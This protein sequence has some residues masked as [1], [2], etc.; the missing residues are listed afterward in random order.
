[1]AA[2]LQRIHMACRSYKSNMEFC[3]AKD[4]SIHRAP[5]CV[6]VP[7]GYHHRLDNGSNLG[8]QRNLLYLFFIMVLK[9]PEFNKL[10]WLFLI[11]KQTI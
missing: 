3:F 7:E 9:V 4:G 8:I 2:N 10:A 6:M 1:M 11:V 5:I